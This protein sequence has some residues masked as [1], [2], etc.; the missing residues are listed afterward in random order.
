MGLRG[1][2]P[3]S[4]QLKL[5]RGNPGKRSLDYE[6]PELQAATL[7]PPKGLKKAAKAE[8]KRIIADLV[9]AGMLTIGDLE[10]FKLYCVLVGEVAEI[11]R[12]CTRVKF[13]DSVKLGYRNQLTK[14]RAQ[15]ILAA[16]RL[17]LSPTTRHAVKKIKGKKQTEQTRSRF[18]GERSQA[19]TG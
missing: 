2:Q 1:P 4:K 19:S 3:Q 11:E 5:E 6:E 12:V 14:T 8:W 15:L 9:G 17:G 18:F 16:S 7:A 10:L 13:A